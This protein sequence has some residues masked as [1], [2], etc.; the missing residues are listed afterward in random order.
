MLLTLGGVWWSLPKPPLLDGI[1][2]SQRVRDR[3]G[4]VLRVTLTSDD[5]YR[6]WTPLEQ[7]SPELIAATLRFE[8]RHFWR[9]PGVNPVA[10]FRCAA[11]FARRGRGG[12]G[13]ST[14]TMQ[15][16]RLRFQLHTKT[17]R[18]KLAQILRA[19][20]LERHYSK[21]EILE[22]YLNL[23]PYGRNIEGAEAASELLL[24]KASGRSES[25][26]SGGAERN[27]ATPVTQ[28]AGVSFGGGTGAA[29]GRS[30]FCAAGA[31]GSAPRAR[32]RHDDARPPAATHPGN[33]HRPLPRRKPLR[34]GSRMQ[35]RC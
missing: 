21:R 20:E 32:R 8:D 29:V 1:D 33:A 27:P 23:A 15:L 9:H 35:R 11:R 5:K 28:N 22:A 2:F 34:A 3:E 25:A 10:L 18:G 17:V 12:A 19:V 31:G 26:G 16:A 4:R 24:G 7:I 14:I 30:A 13:A 6:L